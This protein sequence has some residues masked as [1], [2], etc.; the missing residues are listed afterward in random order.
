MNKKIILLMSIIMIV[1]FSTQVFAY[2]TKSA[3]SENAI[4]Y[5]PS[6]YQVI[7]FNKQTGN[8]DTELSLSVDEEGNC[9]AFIIFENR[10]QFQ[11][12]KNIY[13][14]PHFLIIPEQKDKR[15]YF[16]LINDFV[17][18][19]IE[20]NSAS[21]IQ[22]IP[23]DSDNTCYLYKSEEL[24]SEYE[25]TLPKQFCNFK[26]IDVVAF[27][28]V[29]LGYFK[30]KYNNV[31]YYYNSIHNEHKIEGLDLGRNSSDLIYDRYYYN[32]DYA[33]GVPVLEKSA[34]AEATGDDKHPD[35]LT[36][37]DVNR[38]SETEPEENTKKETEKE[39]ETEKV[40]VELNNLKINKIINKE[41]NE[42]LVYDTEN[43]RYYFVSD[44]LKADVYLDSAYNQN[45]EI[46]YLFTDI[47]SLNQE[48]INSF[49]IK[50]LEG[51]NVTD[52]PNVNCTDNVNSGKISL[53]NISKNKYLLVLQRKD[54]TN[55][56]VSKTR[57]VKIS[58]KSYLEFIRFEINKK[59]ANFFCPTCNYP[60]FNFDLVENTEITIPEITVEAKDISPNQT[61]PNNDDPAG[62]LEQDQTD[63]STNTC[64]IIKQKTLEEYIAC[65]KENLN[66]FDISKIYDYGGSSGT[67]VELMEI[68][69]NASSY[70]YNNSKFNNLIFNTAKKLNLTEE[71]T[72]QLWAR[73]AAES[74]CSVT[75]GVG[76]DCGSDGV[77]QIMV[78][79]WE[80]EY[81]RL[82]SQLL[83][84]D[85]SKYNTETKYKKELEKSITDQNT[86]LEISIAIN[87]M[88]LANVIN[89]SKN[90]TK[91]I[92]TD[93]YTT[94]DHN[95]AMNVKF[96]SAYLYCS[97][98]Y[99]FF[100]KG[101]NQVYKNEGCAYTAFHKMGYYL[102]YKRMIY[103]C[104]K[105]ET[106]NSFVDAYK[107]NYKGKYC[108]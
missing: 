59:I 96:I 23:N 18:T 12:I 55:L 102:G 5:I 42:E 48:N 56:L 46:C 13:F 60:R 32:V 37:I 6:E 4:K 74:G 20:S 11:K 61:D 101:L 19:K 45:K 77:A 66:V 81:N 106:S 73:I 62:D 89:S 28:P 21:T 43:D 34:E 27:M 80:N 76:S 9:I 14:K 93:M 44:N 51:E 79:I 100:S 8:P 83:A 70:C 107:D 68:K 63:D 104:S 2:E 1:L 64:S 36:K 35:V 97:P 31:Y 84:I 92:T 25:L 69:Y 7:S 91:P 65:L 50:Y 58:K 30:E 33:Y 52:L 85:S 26:K 39:E 47:S 57:I 10:I 99:S 17:K 54:L 41:T 86:S 94:Y 3:L 95:S 29:N 90:S 87:R 71:E 105:E 67:G 38:D 16:E 78:N 82:K 22:S 108:K 15:I 98:N 75:C 53:E 103:K 24:L 49:V 88:N 40:V 72:A